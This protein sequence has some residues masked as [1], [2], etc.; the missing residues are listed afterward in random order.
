MITASF[1]IAGGNYS[2]FMISGHAGFSEKG[3]D[4]VCA[5]VS[6]MTNLT[7]NAITERFGLMAITEADEAGAIVNFR[8]VERNS[9]A[10]SLLQAFCEELTALSNTYPDHIAVS[11]NKI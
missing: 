4:I 8:L 5:A 11:V 2:E 3:T 6:A 1:V 9:C 10:C 7:V